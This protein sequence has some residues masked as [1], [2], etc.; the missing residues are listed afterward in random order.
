MESGVGSRS[1][2]NYKLVE[3]LATLSWEGRRAAYFRKELLNVLQHTRC[4]PDI[5]PAKADGKLGGG[6]G[7]AAV[8]AQLV[9]GLCRRFR[10]G[11]EARHLG[12]QGGRVCGSIGQLPREEWV[13]ALASP[14][15]R[16]SGCR[17]GPSICWRRAG[18]TK[19][20]LGEWMRQGVTR[21]R[22]H[23]VHANG[24]DGCRCWC[25]T[26]WSAGDGIHG[27]SQLQR[28]PSLQLARRLCA[29]RSGLLADASA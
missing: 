25:R 28:D 23:A 1:S 6:D 18:T 10:W 8:H 7:A 14:G 12:Q 5:T 11:R 16:R 22:R 4:G 20:T 21:D 19:R 13:A 9:S 26:A 3:A 29:R 15:G 27:V 24:C 2:G 17:P